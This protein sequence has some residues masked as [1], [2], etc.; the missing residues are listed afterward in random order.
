[1]S[2][3]G[4][5]PSSFCRRPELAAVVADGD[6]RR[7]IA[8]AALEAA[9]QRREPGAA[10]DRDDLVALLQARS[11]QRVDEGLAVGARSRCARPN[12]ATCRT[13]SDEQHDA[14]DVKNPR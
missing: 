6:D 11:E 10:A 9:Q 2:P 1:M 4:K 14:D 3:G 8:G 13:P 5:T 12:A 7:E